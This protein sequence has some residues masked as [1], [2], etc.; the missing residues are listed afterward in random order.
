ML[1]AAV[2]S[3]PRRSPAPVGL[4]V[5]GLS[6][7]KPPLPPGKDAPTGAGLAKEGGSAAAADMFSASAFGFNLARKAPVPPP[8]APGVGPG[9]IVSQQSGVKLHQQGQAQHLAQALT[10]APGAV[11]AGMPPPPG[12]PLALQQQQQQQ[13]QQSRA[14]LGL[15][16]SM[17]PPAFPAKAGAPPGM[18]P[19]GLGSFGR[20]APMPGMPPGLPPGM[21]PGM[22]GMGTGR[23]ISPFPGGNPFMTPGV[24]GQGGLGRGLPPGGPFSMQMP[25]AA[26]AAG[27]GLPGVGGVAPPPGL[28]GMGVGMGVGMAGIGL[29]MGAAAGAAAGGAAGSTGS[30]S[31]DAMLAKLAEARK[32]TTAM[33]KQQ[34]QQQQVQQQQSTLL[35]SLMN[36]AGTPE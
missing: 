15:R 21:P 27:R 26:A 12:S 19:P 14:H 32:K 34:Q 28:G 7:V 2:R 22:P 18:M 17:P 31:L 9:V 8:S 33:Q 13:Q 20:G 6:D 11:K 4:L 24:H 36:R 3:L 10:G 23:G 25:G 16:T 1:L 5:R 29:G 35:Q 30:L